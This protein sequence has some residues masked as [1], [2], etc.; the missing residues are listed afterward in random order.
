MTSR[1]YWRRPIERDGH[2][3]RDRETTAPEA[4]PP[5]CERLRTSAPEGRVST[6]R[7]LLVTLPALRSGQFFYVLCV[8]RTLVLRSVRDPT[9]EP[10]RANTA[11]SLVCLIYR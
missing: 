2:E 3:A 1:K 9:I 5:A 6:Q 7:P 8:Y 11:D 4:V 10:G